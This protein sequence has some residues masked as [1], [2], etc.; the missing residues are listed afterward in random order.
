MA[1]DSKKIGEIVW[2]D[3]TI[4][5]AEEVRDFYLAVTGWKASD[6]DMGGYKDYVVATP[7]QEDTVAGIVHARGENADLPPHWLVYIKVRS[8][9]ESMNAAR[10]KGGEVLAGP[11]K[12]GEARFCVIK[13]PAGAVFAIVEGDSGE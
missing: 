11:K 1:G 7:E 13:D 5:N 6:F 12:L 8:L 2:V 3:L 4:P 9:E 10:E